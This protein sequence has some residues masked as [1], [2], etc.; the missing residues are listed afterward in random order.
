MRKDQFELALFNLVR[1]AADAMPGGRTL[2]ISTRHLDAGGGGRFAVLE[3][4]DTGGGMT[5]E[6]IRRAAEPFFTMKGPGKGTGLGLS[7]V[8]DFAEQA[9]GRVEI[10]STVGQGTHLRV[11]LALLGSGAG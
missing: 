11:V 4:A 3:V 10:D 9:G 2:T 1:N 5:P 8:R 7:M 6:V